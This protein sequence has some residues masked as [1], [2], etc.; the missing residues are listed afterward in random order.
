M[1]KLERKNNSSHLLVGR[2]QILANRRYESVHHRLK[3]APHARPQTHHALQCEKVYL[4]ETPVMM[5]DVACT[6]AYYIFERKEHQHVGKSELG[7]FQDNTT[8]SATYVWS[9][10]RHMPLDEKRYMHAWGNQTKQQYP[11]RA[12]RAIFHRQVCLFATKI[13]I[14]TVIHLPSRSSLA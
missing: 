2:G 8:N 3:V 1:L 6:E 12:W 10:R 11:C 4:K 5:R 14:A 13:S 7:V 9:C